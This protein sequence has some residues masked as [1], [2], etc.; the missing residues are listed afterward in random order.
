MI[1]WQ[2]CPKLRKSE[3]ETDMNQPN[4]S[5]DKAK[6][7]KVKTGFVALLHDVGKKKPEICEEIVLAVFETLGMIDLFL[8]ETAATGHFLQRCSCSQLVRPTTIR[9]L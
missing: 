9:K 4:S 3:K 5:L 2:T 1:T 6:Y 8:D 7:A